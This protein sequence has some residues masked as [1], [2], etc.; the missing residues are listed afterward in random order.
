MLRFTRSWL[1]GVAALTP[2]CWTTA[3]AGWYLHPRSDV[4][5][6]EELRVSKLFEFLQHGAQYLFLGQSMALAGE[7]GCVPRVEWFFSE[8]F[9]TLP[10]VPQAEIL[11]N[12]M[13]DQERWR[14]GVR[15]SS[16]GTSVS[17]VLWSREL[18]QRVEERAASD[19]CWV[20][21]Q[22]QGKTERFLQETYVQWHHRADYLV[23]RKSREKREFRPDLTL[24][25]VIQ[26]GHERKRRMQRRRQRDD[27]RQANLAA[28]RESEWDNFTH[29]VLPR[30]LREALDRES[31]GMEDV[32]L[33]RA[34]TATGGWSKSYRTT[35]NMR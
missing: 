25:Q 16:K 18:A 31:D 34:G 7:L 8:L 30:E 35:S 2:S 26:Q 10:P 3:P 15:N 29:D 24:Q 27:A 23:T 22:D 19:F 33:A 20:L 13:N 11:A 9:V 5:E 12:Y 17:T 6:G 14:C 28:G 1:A 4:A 32:R 21:T